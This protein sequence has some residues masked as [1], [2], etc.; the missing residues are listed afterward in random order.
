MDILVGFLIV[1]AMLYVLSRPFRNRSS[2]EEQIYRKVAG[3]DGEDR[4]LR[5]PCPSCGELV[6]AQ[7]KVCRQC[8]RDLSAPDP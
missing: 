3:L 5:V 4:I 8:G 1:V 7:A 6:L 2:D